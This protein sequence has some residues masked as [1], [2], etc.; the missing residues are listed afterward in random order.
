MISKIGFYPIFGIPLIMWLGTLTLLCFLITAG[1]SIINSRRRTH[2]IPLSRH[3]W[4]A[5]ISI[6]LALVHGI[7]GMLA[8]L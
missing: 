4:M 5:R 1:I 3:V 8:F 2:K 6:T 7:L